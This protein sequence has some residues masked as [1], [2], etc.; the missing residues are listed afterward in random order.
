[1]EGPD[2][3]ALILAAEKMRNFL[4][5][6]NIPGIA[7]LKIDVNKG[8]PAMIVRVDREKAGTLG[9]AVGQVGMQLRRSRFWRKSG[10]L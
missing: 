3:D 9:V 2:Y 5:T 4:N 8:K 7:E 10:C 1:M 6:K